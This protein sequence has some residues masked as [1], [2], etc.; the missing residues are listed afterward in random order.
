MVFLQEPRKKVLG[1]I[2]RLFRAVSLPPDENVKGIPVSAAEIF[3]GFGGQRD[4]TVCY[5][6]FLAQLSADRE[7]L[8]VIFFRA[9][10]IILRQQNVTHRH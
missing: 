3:Q 7:G 2:L 9:P 4:L 8:L 1:Q 10:K 5:S 6:T